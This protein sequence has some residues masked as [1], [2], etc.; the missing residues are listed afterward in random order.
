[1]NDK[2]KEELAEF[3]KR[4][5]VRM[6]GGMN[7]MDVRRRKRSLVIVLLVAVTILVLQVVVAWYAMRKARERRAGTYEARLEALSLAVEAE[8]DRLDR[9][10]APLSEKDS[11]TYLWLREVCRELEEHP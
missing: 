3:S 8:S 9:V 5:C 1:M 4:I 11:A 2:D 10:T 6:S 7:R